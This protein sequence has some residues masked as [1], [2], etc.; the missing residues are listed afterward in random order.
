MTQPKDIVQTIHFKGYTNTKCE[1]LPCHKGVGDEF[2]CLFCYC[3]LAYL[4]CIGPYKVFTDKHGQQRKDCSG[5]KLPHDGYE[6]S[7]Q[8]IQNSLERPV[9]WAGHWP[10]L[11]MLDEDVKPGLVLRDLETGAS[12]QVLSFTESEAE[13]MDGGTQQPVK[14]TRN[15]FRKKYKRWVKA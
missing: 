12:L 4:E 14:L 7:W 2:N 9:A 10:L 8:F 1:F 3:P 5:C 13:F 11:N 15:D 6:K